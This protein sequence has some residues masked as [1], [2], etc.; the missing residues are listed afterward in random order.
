MR[1]YLEHWMSTDIH[2]H[3]GT[4]WRT[5]EGVGDWYSIND[6][7]MV[8]TMADYL[9]WTGDRGWLERTVAA[10]DGTEQRVSDYLLEYARNWERFKTPNGL[11]DYGGIGNLLEC[12]S[13]YVHEVA[14][15]NA[16]NVAGLRTAADVFR[17]LMGEPGEAARL[18][19]EADALV[20]EVQKLYA[21]GKGFWHTRFPDGWLV[22]VRHCYDLLAILNSMS[23]DLS[24]SQR[25]EMVR[26][27]ERELITPNWMH[28]LSCSDPDATFT[29]RPDHQW[30]GAY[31]AWPSE[32]A[33]GL[34][35]IG[36]T[37]LAAR[38]M[39][40]VAASA[41]QGPFGQAHFVDSVMAPEG[42]GARKAPPELP[43]ICDWACSSAGS[44]AR[45]VV[46]GVFG[47]EAGLDGELR[48][49]PVLDDWDADARLT[50]LQYQG[51][52]YTVD[53]DGV[54]EQS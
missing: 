32:T 9:R 53:R 27:L 46:E 52:L 40:G 18:G 51:R 26:F 28:A 2:S 31:T 49:S 4:E 20:A 44:Y 50:D 3:M 7:A 54:H 37:K 47:V 21:D 10:V 11:A 30:T 36:E 19:G 38:W 15:M 13:T 6:S 17:S 5:G 43:Y 45:F 23:A 35:R 48:A 8:R 12:V 1:T 24:P 14:S 34:C 29:V 39:K 22:P 16:S 33:L 25:S 41:N 42:D